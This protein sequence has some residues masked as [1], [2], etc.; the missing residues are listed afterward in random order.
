MQSERALG[1]ARGGEEREERVRKGREGGE[2]RLEGGGTN[3][4]RNLE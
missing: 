1:Q 2:D 3:K 4:S